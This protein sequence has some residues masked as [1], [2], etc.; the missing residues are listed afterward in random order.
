[1]D[2][3]YYFTQELLSLWGYFSIDLFILISLWGLLYACQLH[4]FSRIDEGNGLE[5]D[6][7]SNEPG[8][9]VYMYQYLLNC[10]YFCNMNIN[11]NFLLV[12]W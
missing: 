9:A 6:A 5:M 11:N 2:K 4:F 7:R 3:S 8:L 12:L 10:C 1:M